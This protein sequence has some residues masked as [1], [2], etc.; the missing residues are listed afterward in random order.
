MSQHPPTTKRYTWANLAQSCEI[1][2]H[3]EPDQ[4]DA[5]DLERLAI[6]GLTNTSPTDEELTLHRLAS[7]VTIDGTT[8]PAGSILLLGLQV[9]GHPFWML[10]RRG[11]CLGYAVVCHRH[12]YR[13]DGPDDYVVSLHDAYADAIA[14]A[15][16]RIDHEAHLHLRH[17]QYAPDRDRA[18]AILWRTA[19]ASDATWDAICFAG[20][21]RVAEEI[22]AEDY[23]DEPIDELLYGPNQWTVVRRVLATSNL[24]IYQHDD[25]VILLAADEIAI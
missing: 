19:A 7:P 4:Y 9:P 25:E 5:T 6:A 8:W 2:D 22:A 16:A 12:Y 1:L 14:A 17:N 23:P 18:H 10:A 24:E 21:E 13:G 20:L 3:V 11:R 15:D